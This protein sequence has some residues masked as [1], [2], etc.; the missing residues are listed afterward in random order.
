ML[1]LRD[2]EKSLRDRTGVGDAGGFDEQIVEATFF[3][4]IL[5]AFHEILADGAAK[6]A[7]AKFQDIILGSFDERAVDPD[8]A[9]FIDD[10]SKLVAVL[11]LEDVVQQRG[12]PGAEKASQDRNGDRFG[13]GHRCKV[14]RGLVSRG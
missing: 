9:D 5:H 7:V 4:E 12:F 2:V 8:L 11:L 1:E 14:M 10:D 3:E 13:L 6:A